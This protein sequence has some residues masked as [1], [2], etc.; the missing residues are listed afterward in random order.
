MS[1]TFHLVSWLILRRADGRVLLGRR[2]NVSYGAGLWGLPGGHTLDHETLSQAAAREA[3]E[4]VGVT[5]QP[6]HLRPLGMVRY[7]DGEVRGADFF[8]LAGEWTGE[9]YPASECSEVGWFDP[10]HLPPDALPWLADTLAQQLSGG[11]AWLHE[12]LDGG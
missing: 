7:V 6:D 1:H 3:L 4:E 10:S 12:S 2:A 11:Q 9:A 5:V 8:F